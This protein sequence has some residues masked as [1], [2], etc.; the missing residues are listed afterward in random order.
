MRDKLDANLRDQ[1]SL[2]SRL[3]RGAWVGLS[4]LGVVLITGLV[5]WARYQ[6]WV[7]SPL[8]G[9]RRICTTLVTDPDPPLNV[10]TSPIVAPDNVVGKLQNGAVLV[11]VMEYGDWLQIQKPVAGWVHKDRTITTCS[12]GTPTP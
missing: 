9:T 12:P 2:K 4:I 8:T 3:P 6:G 5:Y 11:V 10:R 7:N 1:K